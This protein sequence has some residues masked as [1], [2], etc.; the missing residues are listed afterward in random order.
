[1]IQETNEGIQLA[2]EALLEKFIV[3]RKDNPEVFR[4]II[5]NEKKL[6]LFMSKNFG[7]QIKLD[8]DTA[9]LEKI[10][11][12]AKKW[13]GINT[14]KNEIDYTFFM[15]LLAILETKSSDDGFLLSSVIEDI[16]LFLMDIYEVDWK[17]HYQRESLA[18]AL[19]CTVDLELLRVLDGN[20]SDFE[21]SE[22]GEVLYQTTHLIRYMFRNLSKPF[23]SFGTVEELLFDGLDI[24]NLTHTILRKVYFEPVVF[25]KELTPEEQ[26]FINDKAN[27]EEMKFNI[28]H[29]TGF[30]LERT[31]Q[32][33]Y[34][35]REERK[36]NLV[37]HPNI[38]GISNVLLHVA[39]TLAKKI[40][41]M[42][43]KPMDLI[44]L[45]NS[46]FESLLKETQHHY[47]LGWSK[48]MRE[49]PFNKFKEAVIKY[50]TEWKLAEYDDM[51][52][53]VTIYP[54]FIRTIGEYE[55]DLREYID[56][57]NAKEDSDGSRKQEQQMGTL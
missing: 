8:S 15:A 18:R 5:Y 24:E 35:T 47:A 11:Y 2:I 45:K 19:L 50:A 14:F 16:K 27:Y 40:E 36:R 38:S 44:Q 17:L 21:K 6:R 23:H 56:E 32:C 57:F 13:M 26:D 9:K 52:M 53:L 46:E 48:T 39:N 4:N 54:S 29:Y 10:P 33:L 1:M 12:H 49:M 30:K 7:F 42:E 55:N 25:F 43:E 28:E 3:Q 41:N 20:I 34:L 22:E 51:T 31:Y 37:Q